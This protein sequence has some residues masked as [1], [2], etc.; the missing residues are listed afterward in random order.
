MNLDIYTILIKY[1]N[2]IF[3]KIFNVTSI[4]GGQRNRIHA[5]EAL[6]VHVTN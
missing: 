6:S 2:Q 3:L 5:P 1:I 4:N